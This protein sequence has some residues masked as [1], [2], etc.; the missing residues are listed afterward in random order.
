ML[1]KVTY[2]V[3]PKIETMNDHDDNVNEASK[4]KILDNDRQS[5][6]MFEKL[7]RPYQFF[8]LHTLPGYTKTREI[9]SEF[10]YWF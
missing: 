2:S 7:V 8:K 4:C 6:N 9:Q 1:R 3:L 10:I 5:Q